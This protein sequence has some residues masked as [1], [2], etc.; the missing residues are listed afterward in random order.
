VL[1]A[2][3]ASLYVNA[4][5]ALPKVVES[6]LF[7]EGLHVLGQPPSPDQL[8][9]YLSA[10]FG[11]ALP[12]EAVDAVVEVGEAGVDAVRKHLERSYHQVGQFLTY[13]SLI[14]DACSCVLCGRTTN[15]ILQVL[16]LLGTCAQPCSAD[17][18]TST[19]ASAC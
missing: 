15:P 19:I 14:E 16:E 12:E 8:R 1:P 6:R 10:Y 5:G 3:V 2:L 18:Y 7:S 11:D 17:S 4:C 9:Q 13:F